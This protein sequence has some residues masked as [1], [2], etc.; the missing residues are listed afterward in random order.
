MFF[1]IMGFTPMIGGSLHCFPPQR[2]RPRHRGGREPGIA[3][4]GAGGLGSWRSG[5]LLL[6]FKPLRRP[7]ARV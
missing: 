6:M 5:V 4:R 7:T 1:I 3:P 2:H